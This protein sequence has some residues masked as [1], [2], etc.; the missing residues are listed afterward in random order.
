MDRCDFIRG[1]LPVQGNDLAVEHV[2]TG[3]HLTAFCRWRNH[4]IMTLVKRNELAAESNCPLDRDYQFILVLTLIKH[5]VCMQKR[6]ADTLMSIPHHAFD[7]KQNPSM[8]MLRNRCSR[9]MIPA[10]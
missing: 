9:H 7:Y 10:P 5:S 4:T 6:Q 1:R 8:D 3:S 2:Q